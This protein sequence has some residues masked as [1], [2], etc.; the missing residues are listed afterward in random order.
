MILG[1]DGK[2]Y[3]D[4][5]KT[6]EITSK[7]IDLIYLKLS[8]NSFITESTATIPINNKNYKF[9]HKQGKLYHIVKIDNKEEYCFLEF[10]SVKMFFSSNNNLF[11]RDI[12][13]YKQYEKN[14]KY[15]NYSFPWS[16]GINTTKEVINIIL[17]DNSLIDSLI[18]RNI[19][20]KDLIKSPQDIIS[21]FKDLSLYINYYLKS[22]INLE[23]YEEK[24]FLDEDTFSFNS[25]S[26]ITFFSPIKRQQF[27]DT[28][29]KNFDNG[30]KEYFFTGLPSIGKTIT[31]LSFNSR[32]DFGLKKAY[33]NLKALKENKQFI[34]IIIYESQNLFENYDN[35]QN[36]FNDLKNKINETNNYLHI[37][38]KLIELIAEKYTNKN[39]KYIFILDQIKFNQVGDYEYQQIKLIRDIIKENSNLYLIGCCSIND[40]G[41]KHLLFY[42]WFNQ[43]LKDDENPPLIRYAEELCPEQEDNNIKQTNNY[44]EL[45]GNIPIYKN[46]ENK[47]NQKIIN[48]LIKKTKTKFLKFYGLKEFYNEKLEKIPVQKKFGDKK[49]FMEELNIIPIKYFKINIKEKSFDYYCPLI[50][51]AIEELLEEK[52]LDY[53]ITHNNIDLGWRFEKRVIHT[54]KSTHILSE[55]YYVDRSFLIPTIFLPFKVEGLNLSENSFFYFEYCNVQRYNAAIYFGNEK[56]LLLLQISLKKTREQLNEYNEKNF[57]EDIDDL[58]GFITKNQLKVKKYSLLFIFEAANYQIKSNYSISNGFSIFSYYF[59]DLEERKFEK[60]LEPFYQ[61]KTKINTNKIINNIKYFEFGKSEGSFKFNYKGKYHKYYAVAGM[62]LNNFLNEIFGVDFKEEFLE[63]TKI[64]LSNLSLISDNCYFDKRLIYGKEFEENKEIL[65]LNFEEGY[66]YYGIGKPKKMD[67][68]SYNIISREINVVENYYKKCFLFVSNKIAYPKYFFERPQKTKE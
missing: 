60:K 43:S 31:L 9:C 14:L 42:N 44:L 15:F 49:T 32:K 12:F 29:L 51:L 65:L 38:V 26:K 63:K 22:N 2:Y 48:I 30:S 1:D 23:K 54:I 17:N 10:S 18:I 40:K 39:F 33:F 7:L 34:D 59:Y 41:V 64:S 28:I 24:A 47:L 46:F 37:L 53:Y 55:K 20:F 11:E 58:Q 45:L 56:E 6:I 61:I 35:W 3:L 5:E 62:S 36:A 4:K 52:E 67:W 50:K 13:S 66:I 8:G 16:E 57:Q 27:V 21:V 68:K 19:N 25:E